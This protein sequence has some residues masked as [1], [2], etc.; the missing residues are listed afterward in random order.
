MGIC[1]RD[2]DVRG[3]KWVDYSTVISSP[4]VSCRCRCAQSTA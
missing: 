2:H 3:E 4:M 1:I